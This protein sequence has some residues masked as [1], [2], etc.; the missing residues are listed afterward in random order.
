MNIPGTI[1]TPDALV[2]R[3]ELITLPPGLYLIDEPSRRKASYDVTTNQVVDC[4]W[5]P[6]ARVILPDEIP[7]GLSVMIREDGCGVAVGEMSI[8]PAA[9]CAL[10]ERVD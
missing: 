4:W 2:K 8:A 3:N 6:C 5:Q 9:T 1:P 10:V 7:G